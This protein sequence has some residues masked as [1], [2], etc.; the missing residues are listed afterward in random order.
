MLI[1]LHSVSYMLFFR[2]PK[3]GGFFVGRST[4]FITGLVRHL[5]PL[6][7]YKAYNTITFSDSLIYF[8]FFEHH[9]EQHLVGY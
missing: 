6:F 2:F 7:I 4:S 9:V 1:E 3:Y 8:D 5:I